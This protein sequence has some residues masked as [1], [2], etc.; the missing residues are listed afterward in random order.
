M[1]HRLP[2]HIHPV[3]VDLVQRCFILSFFKHCFQNISLA[4]TVH[5]GI[6]QSKLITPWQTLY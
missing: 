4:L 3:A 5:C 2:P 1:L 6:Y